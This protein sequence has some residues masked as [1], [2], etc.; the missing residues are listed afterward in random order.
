M[1]NLEAVEELLKTLTVQQ[2]ADR[3]D[4]K[5]ST[6]QFKLK[7]AGVNVHKIKNEHAK[8]ILKPLSG[9]YSFPE[10]AK[11]TY[12]SLGKVKIYSAEI[13]VKSKCERSAIKKL[14]PKT[15]IKKPAA[16]KN[17]AL[18]KWSKRGIIGKPGDTVIIRGC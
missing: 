8:E 2:I 13:G 9:L 11:L 7:M 3:L 4:I 12:L 14:K 17:P 10:M 15:S 6:L 5:R 1:F 16:K 18:Q